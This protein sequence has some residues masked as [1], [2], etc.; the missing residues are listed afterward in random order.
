MPRFVQLVETD[1]QLAAQ[2]V[3]GVLGRAAQDFAHAQEVGLLVADDARI[4]RNGDFAVGECVE[5]VDGLV[6]RLVAGHVYDDLDLLGRVVVHA[7]DLDL[8]LLVG[9]DDRLLDRLGG[10]RVGYFGDGERAFVNLRDA[11]AH[12]HR[13]APQSV[14][15]AAHVRQAPRGEVGP[16]LEVAALEVGDRRVDQLVEVVGQD[17]RGQAHGDAVGTLGQQQRELDGQRHGLLV[18][19]VVG[20]HPLRGLAVEHHVEGEFRQPRLDVSAGRRLVAREDVAPVALAVDQQVLLPQLHQRVL[21][22]GVAVRM[23]L[24][25]LAHDVGHLVIASVIDALHGVEYASLHGLQSV[26]RVGHGTLQDHVGGVVEEPVAV[27]AREL[28]HVPLVGREAAVAPRLHRGALLFRPCGRHLR[29]FAIFVH[30]GLGSGPPYDVR[31]RVRISAGRCSSS[32]RGP[33]RCG[34]CR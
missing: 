18:A 19:A 11:R 8:A 23:V 32:A 30:N 14:V 17:F 21:D 28:A 22:R 31:R 15:V 24:H 1:L 29:S 33:P 25:G 9:A 3:S 2:Q 26:G 10:R 7:A 20:A 34:G 13:P 27:H 5:R 12:L 6:A 4:G 16:Q